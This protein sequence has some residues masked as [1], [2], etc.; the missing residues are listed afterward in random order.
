MNRIIASLAS[1]FAWRHVQTKGVWRYEEN[2]VT[3]ERRALRD[4]PWGHSPLDE[5]WLGGRECIMPPLPSQ[6]SAAKRR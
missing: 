6:G 4:Q 3:G 1:T 5:A 2:S